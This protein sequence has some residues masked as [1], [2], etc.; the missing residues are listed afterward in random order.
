MMLTNSDIVELTAFRR[1]LHRHPELSGQE[2]WTAAEVFKALQPLH[3]DQIVTGLGG[4]GVAAV[5]NGVEAGPTVMFRS[6]LDGLPIEELSDAEYKS[7]ISGKGH[8]C[9]HDGHSTILLGL[10]RLIDRNRPARGRVVLL[11]Q[12]AEED[13]SGAAAVLADPQFEAIKPDWSFSLHNMPSLPFGHVA[14]QSGPVNC[15]SEGLRIVLSGKTSHASVPERGISPALGLA[16]L[17]PAAMAQGSGAAVVPGFRLVTVTHARMGEPA[18]GVAPG[19]AELWLTL[20][21]LLDSDMAALRS[22]VM[23]RANAEATTHGLSVSFSHHDQFAACA[24]DPEATADFVRALD[25]LGMSHDNLILPLRGS[26][27]FGLFGSVSKSAMIFL[28][29]GFEHPMLH[30]P[31]Y[32]FPDGLIAPGVRIFETVLREHLGQ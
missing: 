8:L 4:H 12:P 5:W 22:T 18:F 31:D 2:A 26:E 23:A 6:E 9:G 27:D 10:G 21:T 20:R 14:L 19:H 16:A 17:I 28:G 25:S 7:T 24:N 15:A 13:G 30:N 29:A 3:P 32:D 1:H 11:F